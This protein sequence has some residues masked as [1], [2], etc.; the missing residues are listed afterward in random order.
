M[1]KKIYEIFNMSTGTWEESEM[2]EHEF[3]VLQSRMDAQSDELEAEFQ[4]IS[5]IIAQQLGEDDQNTR[6]MD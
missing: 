1:K 3:N 6:S 5:R 4:I 2:T